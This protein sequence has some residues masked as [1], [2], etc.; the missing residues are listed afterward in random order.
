MSP[1]AFE[2]AVERAR[3]AGA[4]VTDGT[5]A[6]L[7]ARRVERLVRIETPWGVPVEIVHGLATAREPFDSPLVPGGFL[8]KGQGFGHVVFVTADLDGADRFA[9]EVARPS[10]SRT[11]W[12]PTSAVSP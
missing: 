6:E 5:A 3:A 8:T 11:G 2:R 12:R 7:A 9:R 10:S 1:D 4:S